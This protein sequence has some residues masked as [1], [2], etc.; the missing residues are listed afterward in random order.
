[1]VFLGLGRTFRRFVPFFNR[2]SYLIEGDD[3]VRIGYEAGRQP[4]RLE[5]RQVQAAQLAEPVDFRTA[6]H[7]PDRFGN[8]GQRGLVGEILSE[9][10]QPRRWPV[11]FRFDYT[12]V[13]LIS[14]YYYS[15]IETGI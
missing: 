1:M 14:S 6:R 5:H 8:I 13:P 3:A 11:P 7:L 4:V 2:S 9:T 10:R 12:E 15:E